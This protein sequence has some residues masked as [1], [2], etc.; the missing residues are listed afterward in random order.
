[1]NFSR[2]FTDH[3]SDVNAK[4]QGQKS[5]VKVT[6]VKTQFSSLTVFLWNVPTVTIYWWKCDRAGVHHPICR[7]KFMVFLDSQILSG[8]YFYHWHLINCKISNLIGILLTE[9]LQCSHICW[10]WEN[11]E[12]CGS[13]WLILGPFFLLIQKIT[14]IIEII[15]YFLLSFIH[16]NKIKSNSHEFNKID[17]SYIVTLQTPPRE[18]FRD[19]VGHHSEF[20]T[21]F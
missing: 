15:S 12:K 4:G 9:F 6:E 13:Y 20:V 5:K 7:P 1:M 19:A 21:L 14:I 2:V 11:S 10:K 8:I 16:L 17:P 3:R 18:A